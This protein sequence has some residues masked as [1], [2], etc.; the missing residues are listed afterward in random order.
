MRWQNSISWLLVYVWFGLVLSRFCLSSLVWVVW[1]EP[2]WFVLD[3]WF[4]LDWPALFSFGLTDVVWISWCLGFRK[5]WNGRDPSDQV[6]MGQIKFCFCFN[7]VLIALDYFVCLFLYLFA[8]FCFVFYNLVCKGVV[9]GQKLNR[10]SWD[11]SKLGI[12]KLFLFAF[13]ISR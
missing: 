2:C 1:S 12:K 5:F 11:P 13:S 10:L 6:I 7:L 9:M 8:C 3:G 4:D